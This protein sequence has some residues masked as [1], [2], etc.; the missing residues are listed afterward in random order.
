MVT[1]DLRYRE[2]RLKS[3]YVSPE[4]NIGFFN[5]YIIRSKLICDEKTYYHPYSFMRR[6]TVR[7]C[8][9][10]EEPLFFPL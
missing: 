6:E 1:F 8:Y 7:H 4:F 2:R 3:G 10:V 9:I 5:D